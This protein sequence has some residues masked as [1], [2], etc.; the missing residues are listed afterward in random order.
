MSYTTLFN[1]AN[2]NYALVE[3]KLCNESLSRDQKYH[4]LLL[5]KNDNTI[6]RL[7][8]K[9]MNGSFRRFAEGNVQL[10]DESAFLVVNRLMLQLPVSKNTYLAVDEYCKRIN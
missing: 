9:S 7:R 4:W 2:N 5:N 3:I 6:Q 8:F 10:G 1:Y